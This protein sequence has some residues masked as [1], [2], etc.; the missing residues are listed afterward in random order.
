MRGLMMDEPLMISSLLE[1]AAAAH[2][3]AAIVAR[4]PEG[5]VH[6]TTYG[7]ALQRSKQL[8]Q[9]MIALGMNQG[10]RVGSLAWNTHHHFELFYGI[11]GTGAVLHTINP[12]LFDEHLV[13][14][15]NHAED[16]WICVDAATLPIAER[17]APQLPGVRGWIY[18]SVDPEPPQSSL[19]G[20]MS[21]ER[22]LA[23]QDGAYDWPSFDER[24]ASVICY[25]SG[26]PASPRAW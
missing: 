18:M 25:T 10:D 16:R 24:Q 5:G 8:A 26:P 2:G 4:T 19:P 9:A 15:I 7:E 6:R 1:H 12:R 23:A 17:L 21:Y 11:S 20:L 13:Y 14:I 3:S 22:L